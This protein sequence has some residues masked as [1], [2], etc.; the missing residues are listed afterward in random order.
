MHWGERECMGCLRLPLHKA[1]DGR[2]SHSGS[3]P[4]LGK[5]SCFPNLRPLFHKIRILVWRMEQE[6]EDQDDTVYVTVLPQLV[7][8]R[9]NHWSHPRK[10]H[11]D[12]QVVGLSQRGK[13]MP[14]V[15]LLGYSLTHGQK[16]NAVAVPSPPLISTQHSDVILITR[17]CPTFWPIREFGMCSWAPILGRSLCESSFVSCP[18]WI[19]SLLRISAFSFPWSSCLPRVSSPVSTSPCK[20]PSTHHWGWAILHN[21]TMHT[22]AFHTST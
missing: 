20:L 12:T 1:T 9:G 18:H 7:K 8:F 4:V 21:A 2:K 15:R 19:K 22:D 10:R 13:E 17:I 6:C 14:F 3:A 5:L 11:K 16:Q